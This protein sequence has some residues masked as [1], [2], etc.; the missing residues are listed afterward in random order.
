MFSVSLPG[1]AEEPAGHETSRVEGVVQGE[2][3][4]LG[5]D[6]GW[7][8]RDE[9]KKGKGKKGTFHET[10]L[11]PRSDGVP[12]RRTECIKSCARV[13]GKSATYP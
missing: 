7:G 8:G 5:C 3:A 11:F 9:K 4:R 12:E 1:E 2:F 10:L 13:A 6:L